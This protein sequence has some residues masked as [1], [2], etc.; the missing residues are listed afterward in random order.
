MRQAKLCLFFLLLM[1]NFID[2]IVNGTFDFSLF[3]CNILKD[4]LRNLQPGSHEPKKPRIF[5]CGN[6]L[7]TIFYRIYFGSFFSYIV[8]NKWFNGVMVGINPLGKDWEK[9]AKLHTNLNS[10]DNFSFDGD[11]EKWDK[12]MPPQFQ[13]SLN[14]VIKAWF[15]RLGMAVKVRDRLNSMLKRNYSESDVIKVLDI[16][17]EYVIS[18]P[19]ITFNVAHIK[20]HGMPSGIAVTS[21]FNSFINKMYTAYAYSFLVGKYDPYRNGQKPLIADFVKFIIDSVY[22]DDK[23]VSV[24]ESIA[25]WF[26]ALTYKEVMDYIGIGFTPANKGVFV[27]SH[28]PLFNCTFLK[29]GFYYH[30]ILN[31]I[32]G[33]L[34]ILSMCSTLNYVKDEFRKTELTIIKSGNFQREAFLHPSQIY[35]SCMRTLESKLDQI[36]LVV[37]FLREKELVELYDTDNYGSDLFLS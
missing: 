34:E 29:R 23:L 1:T 5:A 12:N 17:L 13:R 6:L 31:H 32:V 3:F 28:Q 36:E 19:L 33:P 25:P 30:H 35:Y 10:T 9:L 15:V 20:S 16:L 22:G 7:L 2:R 14:K 11:Y 21:F 18:T 27:N 8:S 4:E 37:P 26:N 24:K